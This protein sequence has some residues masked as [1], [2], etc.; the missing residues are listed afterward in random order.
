MAKNMYERLYYQDAYTYR[1]TAVIIDKIEENGRFAVT[2]DQTYFYP[3]SGGQPFDKGKLND[4]SV[5]DATV[6]PE[7]GA[8]LHWLDGPFCST[9]HSGME[10]MRRNG[11]SPPLPRLAFNPCSSSKSFPRR[12]RTQLAA[13][14]ADRQSAPSPM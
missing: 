10:S 14:P 6:R 5:V 3:T 4:R 7:D 13:L 1:F 8:V 2:L 9:W 12:N 11:W